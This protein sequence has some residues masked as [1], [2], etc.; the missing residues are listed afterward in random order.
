MEI[1]SISLHLPRHFPPTV[2]MVSP[3]SGATLSG[4]VGVLVQAS[5]PSGI[6]RVTVYAHGKG[7]SAEG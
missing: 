6:D 1:L 2:S 4:T 5:D 7:S 3:A